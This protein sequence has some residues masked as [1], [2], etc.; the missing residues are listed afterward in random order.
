MAEKDFIAHELG[1]SLRDRVGA[2]GYHE[3]V[4]E[5]LAGGQTTLEA[6]IAGWLKSPSHRATLLNAKFTEVG[7][8]AVTRPET[9]WKTF[10]VAGFGGETETFLAEP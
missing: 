8:A 2:A 1:E 5:I 3:S 10:W 6:A 4:G 9:K 7:F